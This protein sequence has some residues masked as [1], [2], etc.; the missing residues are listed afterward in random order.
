MLEADC[1]SAVGVLAVANNQ[2][3]KL[4]CRVLM[5]DGSE[6]IEA[7]AVGPIDN[8]IKLSER[9]AEELVLKGASRILLASSKLSSK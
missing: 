1:H 9:V 6:M 4:S 2:D 8:P 7:K 3:L 5:P